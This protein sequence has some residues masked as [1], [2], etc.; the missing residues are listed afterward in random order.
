MLQ[1]VTRVL[2]PHGQQW[3]SSINLN[4]VLNFIGTATT[5]QQRS[6]RIALELKRM[7]DAAFVNQVITRTRP[8]PPLYYLRAAMRNRMFFRKRFCITDLPP[9]LYEKALKV[10]TTQCTAEAYGKDIMFIRR[11]LYYFE[12]VIVGQPQ[13]YYGYDHSNNDID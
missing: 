9:A 13:T 7:S 6:I 8:Q 1:T 10:V 11:S 4:D 5:T 12:M 2:H 3:Q